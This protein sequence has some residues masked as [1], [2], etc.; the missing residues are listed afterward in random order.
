MAQLIAGNWK[1]HCLA[2]EAIALA[3]GDR[4]RTRRAS[5]P[6]CWSARPRLHVAA[7]AQA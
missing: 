7:V 4:R 1:M 2:A 6:N 3:Q 5:L